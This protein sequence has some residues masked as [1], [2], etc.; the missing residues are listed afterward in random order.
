MN[1]VV[2]VL[3]M[4]SCHLSFCVRFSFSCALAGGQVRCSSG[5]RGGGHRYCCGRFV[6]FMSTGAV[7]G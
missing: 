7:R 6:V 1:D 3:C 5:V 4:L 2:L